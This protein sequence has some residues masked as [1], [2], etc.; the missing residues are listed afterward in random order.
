M[1]IMATGMHFTSGLT[2]P[3]LARFF[4]NRQRIHICAQPN[5]RS[6]PI[7]FDDAHDTGFPNLWYDLITAE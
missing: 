4:Q 1:A 5:G 2:S 7:A 6:G 3:F